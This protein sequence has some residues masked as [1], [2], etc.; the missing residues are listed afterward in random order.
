MYNENTRFMK[1]WKYMNKKLIA[2]LLT[3]LMFT[4]SACRIFDEVKTSTIYVDKK[5]KVTSTTVASLPSEQYDEKELKA[6]IDE[7]LSAYNGGEEQDK[8]TLKRFKVKKEQATLRLV[9][10]SGDDYEAFNERILFV[11]TVAE[12][13]VAGYDFEGEFQDASKSPVKGADILKNATDEKVIITNEPVQI[14]TNKDIIYTSTN[15]TILDKRLAEVEAEA[16][17]IDNGIT[18]G[19]EENAYIIYG[20][21]KK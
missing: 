16:G 18:F 15:A 8:I 21:P 17:A 11:G 2:I 14:E 6:S 4:L 5:G 13:K 12:A 9:Y 3:M 20:E 10:A 1:E 19:N 7:A